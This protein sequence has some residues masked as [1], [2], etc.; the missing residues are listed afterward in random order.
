MFVACEKSS[1]GALAQFRAESR[2]YLH[3]TPTGIINGVVIIQDPVPV[4]GQELHPPV[5]AG[6]LSA[7][8]T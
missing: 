1:A 3:S 8:P 6:Q 2:K 4:N 7:T 5:S